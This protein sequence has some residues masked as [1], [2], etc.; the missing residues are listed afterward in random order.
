FD[1]GDSYTATGFNLSQSPQPSA[2]NPFGNP[3]YPGARLSGGNVYLDIISSTILRNQTLIYNFAVGAN[4]VNYSRA[5]FSPQYIVQGPIKDFRDQ[6][7][8]FEILNRNKR[9]LGWNTTN[10]LFLSFFGVNDVAVQIYSG[11]NSASSYEPILRADVLDYWNLVERQYRL[12]GRRFLTVLV[13]PINRAPAFDYGNATNAADVS[14]AIA[15]WN[16][17]MSTGNQNFM[18]KWPNARSRIF[19]PT[20]T[21]NQIL[22]NPRS[23][24]APNAT[25]FSLPDGQPCLWRDFIHPGIRLH[26]ALGEAMG[27]IV[28]AF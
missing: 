27:K 9:T 8:Q 11:R 24:G 6:Q 4:P 28:A 15:Y 7:G 26:R 18:K 1:S 21:F 23:Y 10:S 3:A 22:D 20:S 14:R 16:S 2:G 5:Q 12:G 13:P 25:C 17:Q 19:D